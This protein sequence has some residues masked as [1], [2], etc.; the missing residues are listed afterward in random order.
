[1]SH[2][3][4]RNIENIP[5]Q[6]S[7]AN[8]LRVDKWFLSNKHMKHVRTK[9]TH[10]MF[11]CECER[12]CGQWWTLNIP[13]PLGESPRPAVMSCM[14]VSVLEYSI[15]N[16]PPTTRT[17][18][19]QGWQRHPSGPRQAQHICLPW[20]QADNRSTRCFLAACFKNEVDNI[21]L[22]TLTR[23]VFTSQ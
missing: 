16:D 22:S 18:V 1:M 17:D 21:L 12:N 9:A 19:P 5:K 13:L 8:S 4:K 11:V 20:F 3:S 23:C 7:T 6:L 2:S 14:C 15:S 10:R